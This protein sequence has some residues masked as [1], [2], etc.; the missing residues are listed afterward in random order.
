[1]FDI[2]LATSAAAVINL[3][4]LAPAAVIDLDIRVATATAAAAA[5]AAVINLD[6]RLAPAAS[7][8]CYFTSDG[9]LHYNSKNL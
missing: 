6:V 1:M 4:L 5:A 8:K 3:H 2:R 9:T 7:R